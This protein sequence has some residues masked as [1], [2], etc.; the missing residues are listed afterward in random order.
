MLIEPLAHNSAIATASPYITTL[1]F[2]SRS[3]VSTYLL[4][5]WYIYNQSQ[6]SEEI[7]FSYNF[8]CSCHDPY[9]Y[10]LFLLNTYTWKCHVPSNPLT[11]PNCSWHVVIISLAYC[12]CYS[13]KYKIPCSRYHCTLSKVFR[14]TFE[15]AR[16][17]ML[18]PVSIT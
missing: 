11:L 9:I 4:S 2:A 16:I 10:A 12:L 7:G 14:H 8:D 3:S 5:V 6:T 15:N 13:Y 1:T 17:W 18:S